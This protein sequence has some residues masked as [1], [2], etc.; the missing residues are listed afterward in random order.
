MID[1]I[2]PNNWDA[3]SNE[4]IEFGY[5]VADISMPHGKREVALQW[6]VGAKFEKCGCSKN[7]R[8][9]V[10]VLGWRTIGIG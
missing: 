8:G 6:Y 7:I 4:G 5:M 9:H 10:C 3:V 1:S 2:V